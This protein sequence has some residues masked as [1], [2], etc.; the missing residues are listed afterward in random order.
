VR[1]LPDLLLI[2]VM[3]ANFQMLGTMRLRV[4]I[5]A[6]GAQ[7]VVLGLL[8]LA[9]HET[10]DAWAIVLALAVIALKGVAI[11]ALLVRALRNKAIR[12]EVEPF[13][14]SVASLVLGA[15]ATG[16]SLVFAQSLPLAREHAGALLVPASLATVLTGFL[17]LCTRRK[18]ITQVVGYLTLENGIFV[19][20]L[21]LLDAI[22]YLVEA[23]VLLDLFVLVLVMGIILDHITREF[24]SSEHLTALRE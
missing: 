20:G 22:P 9:A 11:P 1:D 10:L 7:G 5:R 13:I 19:F 24:A 8:S 4:V 14:G 2:L 3:L 6:A 23:G 21:A 17:V 15:L 16:L 18:A 12:R